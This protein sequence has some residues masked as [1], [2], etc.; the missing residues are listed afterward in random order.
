MVF[1]FPSNPSLS[2]FL[3]K[4]LIAYELILGW[5]ARLHIRRMVVQAY[6]SSEDLNICQFIPF[7][8]SAS[9]PFTLYISF[10]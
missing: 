3:H 4:Q 10:T 7:E 2:M 5:R 9:S 8:N 1:K 6:F